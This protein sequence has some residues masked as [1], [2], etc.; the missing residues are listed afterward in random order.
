MTQEDV[1]LLAK[2]LEEHQE[3]KLTFLEKEAVKAVLR[4]ANTVGEL[5]DTALKLL[6][7][8]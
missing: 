7:Q 8:G 4:K 2:W 5:V 6:K 3:H 1:Q